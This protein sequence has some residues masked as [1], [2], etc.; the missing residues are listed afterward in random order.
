MI[1]SKWPSAGGYLGQIEKSND[2]NKN[3][4]AGLRTDSL[5]NTE[6]QICEV[7][8]ASAPQTACCQ[9]ARGLVGCAYTALMR[10][11]SIKSPGGVMEALGLTYCT[12]SPCRCLVTI[13]R[14][15]QKASLPFF[16]I[17]GDHMACPGC[18]GPF[19]LVLSLG[20]VER[21]TVI[22]SAP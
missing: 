20:V 11:S 2:R 19:F 17:N 8:T 22:T 13:R 18:N 5:G 4:T 10:S 7:Q 21:D 9:A 1:C 16:N 6:T 3:A 12:L 14:I 15:S